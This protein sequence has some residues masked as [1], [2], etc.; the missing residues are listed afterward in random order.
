MK[1]LILICG[2]ACATSSIAHAETIH[3]DDSVDNA[4]KTFQNLTSFERS[5]TIVKITDFTAERIAKMTLRDKNTEISKGSVFEYVIEEETVTHNVLKC[6]RTR[7]L[8]IGQNGKIVSQLDAEHIHDTR[9]LAGANWATSHD[10]Y[11]GNFY[12]CSIRL[13]D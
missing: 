7:K 4:Q 11:I 12:S 9:T 6:K 2:L 1:Y 3:F 13:K 10:A 8:S 5:A